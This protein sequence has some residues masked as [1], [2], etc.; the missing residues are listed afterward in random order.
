MIRGRSEGSRPAAGTEEGG[1][2]RRMTDISS[3]GRQS[4]S[5]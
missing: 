4:P 2:G 5:G 1:A 3:E